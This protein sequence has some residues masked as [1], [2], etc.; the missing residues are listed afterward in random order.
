MARTW[1]GPQYWANRLSD[2]RLRDGR[3]EC[4]KAH[5]G[6]RTIGLLTRSIVAGN[7]SG[8]LAVRTGTLAK[9]RGFSGFVIGAGAGSLDW[10]A[11]ALVMG[12]SG[13][14]GGFLAVYD[15]SGE[16]QFRE[17]IDEDHQFAHA[18]LPDAARFGPEPARTRDEDVELRLNIAPMGSHAFNL[19]LTASDVVSGRLLSTA[20]RVDVPASQL[21]GGLS[22]VSAARGG[23]PTA[24]HWFRELRTGGTKI[25][26]H[27]RSA[28]PVL[29]TLYSVHDTVLKLTAQFMPIGDA[30][31]Q[32]AALQV[33]RPDRTRWRTVDSAT[34][35]AGFAACFRV[36]GWE[37]DR[38]WKYRVVYVD[39]AG[40]QSSWS[41]TIRREP[42][43]AGPVTVATVNCTIHSYRNLD[44]ASRDRPRLPGEQYLGLYTTNSL[45][46]PYAELVDNIRRQHPD[47]LV[48]HGDQYYEHKP[49][50][51]DRTR[52]ELD[53]LGRYYLWLLSFREVTRSVPTICLVD[54]HDVYHPNLWGWSGRPAPDGDG[55]YGGYAMN[56]TWV[57]TVQRVQCSHNPDVYDPTP[58]EQGISVYYSAFSYG[59]VSFCVLEDRKFKTTNAYGAHPDGT[60]LPGTRQLLGVRQERF[61][62]AW[63]SMHP[64]QPKVCLTQSV[65]AC[66]QTDADGGPKSDAD[67]NGT[68]V[69]GRRTAVRLLRDAGALVLSGDQ[70][71]GTLVRHGLDTHIDG[72]VQF[73]APAAGSS[74]QRWFEPAGDLPH[75]NGPHTGDFTDGFGNRFRVLAVANPKV[76]QAQVRAVQEGNGVGDRALK[77]EGYG[78]VRV[79]KANRTYRIECWPWQ[80]DPTAPD[81]DQFPGWPYTLPFSSA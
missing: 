63:R 20:T 16:V 48:A 4:L 58:V 43:A 55:S 10:R 68:P 28:G 23:Q 77:R 36:D 32:Q 72:P 51:P 69:I 60:P 75:A 47:L 8:S 1:L 5:R 67:S 6:G 27:R 56:A 66:V 39:G 65:F 57:N 7:M 3:F 79:D 30:E 34:I 33:R 22:L 71:F 44:V 14:G 31:P 62:A 38:D 50:H 24:R 76:T 2:W 11:A 9:G 42:D 26:A 46:F 70:H 40:Q 19:T 13:V 17:H 25:A 18:V 64:G 80:Q 49:T 41:G 52:P 78:I 37:A 35:G 21:V 81:A 73:T 15:S 12:A 29:A 61:L 54:D 74:Y 59:G 53:M 45:Y